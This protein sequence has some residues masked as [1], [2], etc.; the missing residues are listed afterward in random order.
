MNLLTPHQSKALNYKKHIS[1]T[2]NAGSGK[3]FVLSKRYL[4]I[5]VNEKLP[6]RNIAA[7]T[8]TD[9]AAG[10]LYQKI[11]K[12]I[13]ARINES[14]DRQAIEQLE[15]IRR[16]L[17]SANISTIHSFC[18]DILREHPVEAVIDAN[19]TPIDEIFADEL[20]ELSVDEIIKS[21]LE[22]SPDEKSLKYLIRL[23]SSK[24]ILSRELALSI[25]HRRN[26]LNLATKF[27]NLPEDA[28][29]KH[30]FKSFLTIAEKILFDSIEEFID[31]VLTINSA[32]LNNSP[33]NLVAAE[34]GQILSQLQK[35]KDLEGNLILLAKLREKI[36]VKAGTIAIKGYLSR[37]DSISLLQEC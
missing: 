2:A 6:L 7:I 14:V 3:T 26:L 22:N 32:V 18:I 16:Q 17:V 5:A 19:F 31:A 10:E 20:I 36:L 29:A 30:F 34:V 12:E 15:M 27:Y 8:F 1:L 21:S 24:F 35:K 9:K 37:D 4:E 25:K 33:K 28:I 13:D 23:F 11:A